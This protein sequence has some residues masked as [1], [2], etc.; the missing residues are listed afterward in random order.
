M[1]GAL[2]RC[3]ATIRAVDPEVVEVMIAAA[4]RSAAVAQQA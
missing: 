3:L 4:P 1:I 2:G